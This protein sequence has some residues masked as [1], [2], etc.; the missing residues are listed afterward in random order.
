[1]MDYIRIDLDNKPH[2]DCELEL[3]LKYYSRWLLS[4]TEPQMESNGIE[5]TSDLD[6][7]DTEVKWIS[8]DD[9]DCQI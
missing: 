6:L 5:Q 3:D 4:Q 8:R 7:V 1:M 9:E 2:D